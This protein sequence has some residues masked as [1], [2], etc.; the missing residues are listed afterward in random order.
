VKLL[1][2]RISLLLDALGD[3]GIWNYCNACKETKTVRNSCSKQT[4]LPGAKECIVELESF[5]KMRRQE[6]FTAVFSCPQSR[7]FT[8]Y[9]YWM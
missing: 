8:Q 2:Q 7:H 3:L 9:V 6:K 4:L 1:H 5:H